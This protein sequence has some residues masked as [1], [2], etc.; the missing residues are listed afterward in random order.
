M[1]RLLNMKATAT[2]VLAI[3]PILFSLAR[4]DTFGR[5]AN[6]FDIEFVPIG[7]PENSADT[8]HVPPNGKVDYAYRMGK[9]EIRRDMIIKANTQSA[10]EGNPLG[11]SMDLMDFV[12]GGPRDNMPATG[13]SWIEAAMFVNWLN[14]SAGYAPAYKF[15]DGNSQLWQ[16]GDA[17]YDPANPIRNT[18]ASYFLPN[19]DEWHKAA[20]YDPAAGVFYNFPTGSDTHPEPIASGTAAGTAVFNQ[21]GPADINLAGGLSPYGTMAQGGNV[22][23]WQETRAARGGASGRSLFYAGG[24]GFE[25][26][27][28]YESPAIGFRVASIPEPSTVLLGV[29]AMVGMCMHKRV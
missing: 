1:G 10:A 24:T 11:I 12:P 19:I 3:F 28:T 21:Q 15:A 9:Y 5:G 4:A 8:S 25:F 14:T 2:L 22:S 29:L 7:S 27:P 16:S 17:G 26:I 18:L 6:Q 20:Y 13:V 23:E